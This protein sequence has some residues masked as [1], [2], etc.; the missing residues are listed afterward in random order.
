[1]RA[2][3]ASIENR[4]RDYQM[5]WSAMKQDRE[6]YWRHWRDLNTYM[7][8]RSARFL[9]TDREH[10][11]GRGFNT[12]YDNTGIF[13]VRTLAAGLQSGVT[14]PAR[15]WFKLTPSDPGLRKDEEVLRWCSSVQALMQTIFSRSNTYRML[16]ASY[17]EL[18]TY[19]TFCNIMQGDF[20]TVIRHTPMTIGQYALAM[21][22]QYRV[23]TMYREF[24]L[25]TSQ[26]VEAFGIDA[27]SENVQ[28]AAQTRQQT[29]SRWTV[30]HVIEPRAVRD[31]G[32]PRASQMPF[33]SVYFQ[34]DCHNGYLLAD[35][36]FKRFPSIC[37]RWSTVADNTYGDSPAMDVLGDV[38][39][40]QHQQL[41]KAQGIDGLTKPPLILPTSLKGNEVN[42]LPGGI[43][44]ADVAAGSRGTNL[45]DVRIDLSHLT[46]DIVDVRQRIRAGMYT[47]LFMAL[48]ANSDNPQMTAREVAERHEEKLLMLGPVLERLE[49]EE[50]SPL[51]NNTFDYIVEAGLLVGDL[52]PPDVLQGAQLEIEF[53][54]LLAQAQ[55]AAGVQGINQVLGTV[56]AMASFRPEVVDKLNV[57][58]IVDGVADMT[59]VDP[60]YIVGSKQVA[61]IRQ[62]RAEQQAQAQQLEAANMASQAMKNVGITAQQPL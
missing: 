4:I 61:I 29:E 55:R 16:Y 58:E 49:T 23:D 5:R 42:A 46:A 48:L 26:I 51:V 56:A 33:A 1:M 37:P 53:V 59:G 11:A 20:N 60:H 32:D 43:T 8:P 13:A 24:T 28:R 52:E 7:L 45:L 25:S 17:E 50:L 38:K 39:Q 12:P 6:N 3:D 19:G 41:R 40:L 27:V 62:Q 30:M 57:D 14:S 21:N 54:G 9:L 34:P 36:G 47:D 22:S 31:T 2:R 15:P 44:Y 18:G 35:E 10:Q